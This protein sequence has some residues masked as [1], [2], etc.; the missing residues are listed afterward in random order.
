MII[1]MKRG[2]TGEDIAH[3]V[4]RLREIGSEAHVSEGQLRTVIGAVG[5]RAQIQQLPWEAFPGVERAVPVLTPFK[6]VSRE[7]QEQDSVI[8]VGGVE[9]GDLSNPG[10]SIEGSV[11]ERL[12]V[13]SQRVDRAQACDGNPACHRLSLRACHQGRNT[14]QDKGLAHMA[15]MERERRKICPLGAQKR[16]LVP[17]LRDQVHRI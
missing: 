6:F 9:V 1:V 8:D 13:E 11:P 5:D 16:D 14:C 15:R 10:A 12:D 3:V 2:A 17:R 4:E 7:F